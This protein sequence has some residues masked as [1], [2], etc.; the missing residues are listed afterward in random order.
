MLSTLSEIYFSVCCV[1]TAAVGHVDCCASLLHNQPT[2][3][4][5]LDANGLSSMQIPFSA[6][7]PGLC[8]IFNMLRDVQERNSVA[9]DCTAHMICP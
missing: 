4:T 3:C 1:S 5:A 2:I 9:P 6:C 7:T 8:K